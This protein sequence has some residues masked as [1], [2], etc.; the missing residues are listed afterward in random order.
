MGWGVGG[1]GHAKGYASW[2]FW[3]HARIRLFEEG[4]L[5]AWM[6]GLVAHPL[7]WG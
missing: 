3:M 1:W 4:V 7:G 2:Y 5:H 6:R